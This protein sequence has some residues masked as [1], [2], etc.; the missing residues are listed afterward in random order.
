[1]NKSAARAVDILVLLAKSP[2][3]LTQFDIGKELDIPKSSLF[4]L[5]YTLMEK[6]VVEYENEK[7][8]TFKL[9]IKVFEIGTSVLKKADLYDISRPYL[10][11][12]SEDLKETLFLGV[13]NGGEVVYL[14]RVDKVVSSITTAV[15]IGMRR[16]IHCTGL[17]K[18]ILASYPQDHVAQIWNM[19]DRT[20]AYTPTTL[21]TLDDLLL[22]LEMTRKRGYAIDNRER[23]NEIF[24]VAVPIFG[25]GDRALA[26]ISIATLYLKMDEE[27]VAEYSNKLINSAL[28]ISRSLGCTKRHL[29]E[30]R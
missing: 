4:D 26:A 14:N 21:L 20:E 29:Y 8:K 9:S 22:D 12:L 7:L 3:P 24:C 17:G 30:M 27:R 28:S 23:E 5:M 18:A 10:E 19:A 16:E 13:E 11:R 2:Q 15:G 1:M 6:G 25:I